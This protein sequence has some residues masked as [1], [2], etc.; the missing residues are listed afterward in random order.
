MAITFN[1]AVG[2]EDTGGVI[3]VDDTLGS[4]INIRPAPSYL[5]GDAIYG[6]LVDHGVYTFTSVVPGI[7]KVYNNTTELT[8]FGQIQIGESDAVLKNTAGTIVSQQTFTAAPIFSNGIYTDTIAE[9]TASAG[10]TFSHKATM[11][12][13]FLTSMGKAFSMGGFDISGLTTPA[14]GSS[15]VCQSWADDHY[16]QKTGTTA[17]SIPNTIATTFRGRLYY[18]LSPT[19]PFE[20]STVKYVKDYV[21]NYLTGSVSAGQQTETKIIVDYLGT[22]EAGKRYTN[23][24]SAMV[25]AGAYADLA[26]RYQVII[27]GGGNTD[28]TMDTNYNKLFEANLADYIDI[29]GVSQATNVIVEDTTYSATTLGMII[30]ENLTIYCDVAS[31]STPAFTNIVFRNVKFRTLNGDEGTFTLTG[32]ILENCSRYD[33]SVTYSGCIGNCLD[34][35]NEQEV[36]LHNIMDEGGA[37]QIAYA[38]GDIRGKTALG[39]QGTDVA[40]PAGGTAVWSYGNL[41][42]F[43]GSNDL[44][45]IDVTGLT[46]GTRITILSISGFTVKYAQTPSGNLATLVTK[47]GADVVMAASTVMNFILYYALGT[48]YLYE[49]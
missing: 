40:V 18:S 1:L 9:K 11:N 12:Q 22:E 16:F 25:A 36:I 42:A 19:S 17:Q 47:T 33:C 31:G 32:C 30:F 21:N 7:Y 44:K 37:Y 4:L 2:Q 5:L 28:V 39:R 45:L 10:I 26:S 15:A 20:V 48:Y 35:D 29:I 14:G 8:I 27:D 41:A 46:S 38:N 3:L 13:L 49:I 43:T 34:L 6:T 24:T 23:I